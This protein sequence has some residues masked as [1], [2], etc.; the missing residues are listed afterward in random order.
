[1]DLKNPGDQVYLLGDWTPA[2]AGSHAQSITGINFFGG[3]IALEQAPGLPA[4][5]PEIYRI[6]HKA[7]HDNLVCAAHDLSEGGLAVAAAEM[8]LAG[9]LGLA[10]DLTP[11]HADPRLALFAES[12]GCLLVSIEMEKTSQFEARF[13][14]FPLI[15]LGSVTKTPQFVICHNNSTFF[16][17]SVEDCLTAYT[18]IPV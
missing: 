3:T 11:L 7:I 1:M 8:A 12:N 5:A 14:N 10:L 17:L 18:T 13:E 6:L 2:L 9:R 4:R 16:A 15:R